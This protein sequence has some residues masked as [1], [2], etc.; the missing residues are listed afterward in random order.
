MKVFNVRLYFHGD[1]GYEIEARDDE[2]AEDLAIDRLS[3]DMPTSRVDYEVNDAVVTL[4]DC[5]YTDQQELEDRERN[6][7]EDDPREER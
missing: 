1:I 2:E 4:A 7:N 3:Q 5:Q 6:I